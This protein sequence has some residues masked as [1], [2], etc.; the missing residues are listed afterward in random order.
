MTLQIL[1]D[2]SGENPATPEQVV[3]SKAGNNCQA[4][5]AAFLDAFRN[6]ASSNTFAA[7]TYGETAN[8]RALDEAADDVPTLAA[9]TWT[10]ALGYGTAS[11]SFSEGVSGDLVICTIRPDVYEGDTDYSMKPLTAGQTALG[12]N[13]NNQEVLSMYYKSTTFNS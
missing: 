13:S 3:Q 5:Q 7:E 6:T 4:C 8:S 9:G 2:P 1:A 11:Y 12:L 10:V